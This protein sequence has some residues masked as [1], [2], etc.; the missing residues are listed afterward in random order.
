MNALVTGGTSAVNGLSMLNPQR[1]GGANG[2]TQLVPTQKGNEVIFAGPEITEK[3]EEFQNEKADF[4][5]S[6]L[7]SPVTSIRSEAVTPLSTPKTGSKETASFD[8]LQLLISLD[9][10][11]ELIHADRES[12]KRT[13]TFAKYPGKYGHKVREAIEEIFIL[14]LKAASDRHIAPGFRM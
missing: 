10:A 8:R 3:E 6:T 13:E 4:P 1:W 5:S 12:L 2:R 11:L 7:Q 9:T 14:M